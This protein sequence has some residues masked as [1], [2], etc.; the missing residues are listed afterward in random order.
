MTIGT[1]QFVVQE[2][3]ETMWCWAGS[4][5]SSL[6]PMTKVA[7]TLVAG[8]EMITRGAPASMW[9]AALAP[10]VNR[11]VDSI[12]TSTPRSA[13]GSAFGSRSENTEKVWSPTVMELS[14]WLTAWARVPCV[15]SYFR[16]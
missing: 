16:R 8:A 13:H 12:T 2:A 15:E 5:V 4:K 10:S 1:K 9:A 6:T 14:V 11:P 3:L 7:S